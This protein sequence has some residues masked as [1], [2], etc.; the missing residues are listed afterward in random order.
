MAG[1]FLAAC[2]RREE[3]LRA[4][5]RAGHG[6][7]SRGS[8]RVLIQQVIVLSWVLQTCRTDA[9]ARESLRRLGERSDDVGVAARQVSEALADR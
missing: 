3:E 7:R 8:Q 5:I 6:V 2:A 4:A 9:H 1:A